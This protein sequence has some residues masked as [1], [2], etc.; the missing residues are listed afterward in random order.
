ME[1]KE[2]VYDAEIFPLMGK[3][4]EICKANKIA[5]VATFHT[6]N[7]DDPDLVCGTALT[8]PDYDPPATF[9]KMA[10]LLTGYERQSTATLTGRDKDGK[11]VFQEVI[12]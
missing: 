7:D 4:I 8:E 3:I 9:C 1:T 11:I 10:Q 2:D 5:V 12:L 6:P